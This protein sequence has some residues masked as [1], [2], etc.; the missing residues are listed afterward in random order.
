MLLLSSRPPFARNGSMDRM[1][2]K[3]ANHGSSETCFFL[4]SEV[5]SGSTYIA[6]LISYS[7]NASFGYELWDLASEHLRNLND[8]STA[9]DVHARISSLW[10]SPQNIRSSKVMCAALSVISR[11]TRRNPELKQR[12]FGDSAKWI[13]VRRRDKIRQAVSLAVARQSGVFHNYD[14]SAADDEVSVSMKDVEDAL[15]A[16]ILSDEYLRLFSAVPNQCATVFYED[17]LEDPNAVLGNALTNIG[18]LERPGDFELSAVKIAP[19]HQRQ[20]TALQESF[21]EWLLENHHPV[22]VE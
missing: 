10:L 21:S 15:S 16:V 18:L 9:A 20:K 11:W 22:F 3:S 17:V 1:Q 14:S 8:Y 6:E 2:R 5:R 12:V 7:L 13:I 4:A 19:D